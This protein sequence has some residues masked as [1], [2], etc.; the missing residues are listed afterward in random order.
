MPSFSVMLPTSPQY[1]ALVVPE[2][3]VQSTP[4]VW[5]SIRVLFLMLTQ[6]GTT[7]TKKLGEKGMFTFT[8]LTIWKWLKIKL[9]FFAISL[10]PQT[11]LKTLDITAPCQPM[12]SAL[13]LNF[14]D[15]P[16]QLTL[17]TDSIVLGIPWG[18]KTRLPHSWMCWVPACP[19]LEIH[20]LTLQCSQKWFLRNLGRVHQGGIKWNFSH[21]PTINHEKDS[22]EC[23][24]FMC[25]CADTCISKTGLLILC[26]DGC[27]ARTWT[28]F[29]GRFRW[30]QWSNCDYLRI[31]LS[32]S[33]FYMICKP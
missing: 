30:L 20:S 29:A 12:L 10:V 27:S 17:L 14:P 26:L 4:V 28:E 21:L 19:S 33:Q 15:S 32:F 7:K 25:V 31:Y 8:T 3:P 2:A 9:L 5:N 11:C 22:W 16:S 13:A 1:Q 23:C 18:S 6:K 24:M